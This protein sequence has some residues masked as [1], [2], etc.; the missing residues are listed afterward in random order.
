MM[1][2]SLMYLLGVTALIV[3][4]NKEPIPELNDSEAPTYG[5]RGGMNDED[6]D[7]EVGEGD[8]ALSY[9]VSSMNGIP[10]FYGQIDAPSQDITLRVEVIEP[11]KY[12][13]DIDDEELQLIQDDPDFFVHNPACIRLNFGQDYKQYD[14]LLIEDEEGQFHPETMVSFDEFGL[15]SLRLK[16]TDY[17]PQPFT[18]PIRYGFEYQDIDPKFETVAVGN[19]VSFSSL[20]EYPFSE[21]YMNGD[22]ISSELSFE[23]EMPDGVHEIR[24]LVKDGVG[25]EAEHITL[26]R[27]TNGEFKWVLKY[28]YCTLVDQ[29]NYGKMMV[30]VKRDGVWYRSSKEL[31]NVLRSFDVTKIQYIRDASN[32]TEIAVLDVNFEAI[33]KDDS[34]SLSL[35]LTNMTGTIAVGLK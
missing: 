6:F 8:A 34:Q 4:C 22:L 33:L 28:D 2:R 27:I 10:T 18:I 7:I 32:V 23:M 5:F 3:A 9:G 14:N 35:S 12:P 1:K 11:E 15:H 16:L 29:N 26:L 19:V 20:G 31:N 17:G 13:V 30:S 25:N 21:W 24:H